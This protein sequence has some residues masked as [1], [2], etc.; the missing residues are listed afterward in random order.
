M[1]AKAKLYH[2]IYSWIGGLYGAG[3][4]YYYLNKVNDVTLD[5]NNELREHPTTFGTTLL[6]CVLHS[7]QCLAVWPYF[8]VRDFSVYQKTKMARGTMG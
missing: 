5:I 6:F 8:A 3:S 1:S 2:S 4:S 7:G